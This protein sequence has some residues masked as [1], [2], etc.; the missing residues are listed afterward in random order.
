MDGLLEQLDKLTKENGRLTKLAKD[1]ETL[2]HLKQARDKN[3]EIQKL[4]EGNI[5]TLEKRSVAKRQTAVVRVDACHA[6]K[7]LK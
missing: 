2:E 1:C 3:I 4:L 7:E 6:L 5:Q